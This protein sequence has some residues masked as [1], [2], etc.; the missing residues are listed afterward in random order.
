MKLFSVV[1]ILCAIQFM[2][3]SASAQV[4]SAQCDEAVVQD[5]KANV[6]KDNVNAPDNAKRRELLIRMI[7]KHTVLFEMYNKTHEQVNLYR[8][9]LSSMNAENTAKPTM[10]LNTQ[11]AVLSGKILGLSAGMDIL[12]KE[13]EQLRPCL[14][15][16]DLR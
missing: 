12:N 6:T 10:L 13:A 14:S 4:K 15:A 3:L 8:S 7:E 9:Q 2:G 11:I 5:L 1:S 16:V